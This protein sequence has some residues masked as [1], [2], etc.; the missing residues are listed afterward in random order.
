MLPHR[1]SAAWNVALCAD[2]L[3]GTRERTGDTLEAW[4]RENYQAFIDMGLLVNINEE[5]N[6][7]YVIS[8]Y[9][10]RRDQNLWFGAQAESKFYFKNFELNLRGELKKNIVSNSLTH[11]DSLDLTRAELLGRVN[12]TKDYYLSTFA[13]IELGDRTARSLG[14]GFTYKL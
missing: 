4:I 6:V 7:S 5:S 10:V 12:L 3:C 11:S 9:E 14:L 2:D 13:N 1:G 8:Q